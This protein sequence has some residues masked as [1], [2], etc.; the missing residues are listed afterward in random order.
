MGCG[1]EKVLAL[2]GRT[3]EW[4]EEEESQAVTASPVLAPQMGMAADN[5]PGEV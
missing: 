3:G 1:G 4:A 5:V 2:L